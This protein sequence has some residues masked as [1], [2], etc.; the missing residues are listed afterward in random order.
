MTNEM[1]E[2]SYELLEYEKKSEAKKTN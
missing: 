1:L 2:M